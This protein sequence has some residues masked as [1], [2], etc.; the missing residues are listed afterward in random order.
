MRQC[1]VV[2]LVFA[3]SSCGPETV[4]PPFT[5]S[6]E[7]LIKDELIIGPEPTRLRSV[8]AKIVGETSNICVPLGTG[9]PGP[10]SKL[11]LMADIAPYLGDSEIAVTGVFGSGQELKFCGP[12]YSW[13]RTGEF[14]GE[15][16]VAVCYFLS[17]PDHRTTVGD[18]LEGV[19][20]SS[21]PPIKILGVYWQSTSAFDTAN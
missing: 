7:V 6:Y 21:N 1:L 12:S 5:D 14:A 13:K 10:H 2:L 11:E 20:I 15:N 17:C 19:T 4:A 16:E 9:T 8:S 18:K 3:L